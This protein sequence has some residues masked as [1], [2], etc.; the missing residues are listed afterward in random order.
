[1]KTTQLKK[2]PIAVAQDGYALP[3]VKE[4]TVRVIKTQHD[5]DSAIVR[6]LSLMDQEFAAGSSKE[7]EMELLALVIESYERSESEKFCSEDILEGEIE[8]TKPGF[9]LVPNQ[10][11]KLM[12]SELNE[13]LS[14]HWYGCAQDVWETILA[15]SRSITPI[16]PVK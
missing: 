8:T 5:Y 6:L 4:Q 12:Y 1:M 7:Q 10:L 3:Y 11:S 2:D 16:N 15:Q 14:D 9:T 13:R